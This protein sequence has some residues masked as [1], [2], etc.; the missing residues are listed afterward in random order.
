MKRGGMA[1]L[2]QEAG[3][4]IATVDRVLN[5]R[6][7]VRADTRA[8]S[9]SGAAHRASGGAALGPGWRRFARAA[10][11]RGVAQTGAGFLQGFRRRTGPR[12][13][14]GARRARA[15]GVGIFK[16]AVAQ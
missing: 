14:C 7:A 15:A 4:S 10:L 9:G 2:A 6:E 1:E 5:G 11:W 12:R 13:G 3:V 8:H 16:L